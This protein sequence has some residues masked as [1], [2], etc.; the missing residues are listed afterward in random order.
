MMLTKEGEEP[1]GPD[2][3]KSIAEIPIN[4]ATPAVINAV[5]N[6]IGIRFRKLP[7]RLEHAPQ[8]LTERAASRAAE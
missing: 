3:A 5:Y 6:A 7:V 1:L 2:G 8:T 4:K